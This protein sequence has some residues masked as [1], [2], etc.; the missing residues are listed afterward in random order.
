MHVL[1]MSELARISSSIF[2]AYGVPEKQADI[3]GKSLAK[4]NLLGHDSHG[5]IRIP[6]YITWLETGD[7]QPEAKIDI[8]KDIGSVVLIRGN[9]GFGQVIGRWAMEIAI[10]RA[11]ETGFVLMG[12]NRSGHLGRIGEYPEM[13]VEEGLLSLHFVNTHGGGKI[14]APYGGTE[15]RMSANPFAAGIP[16]PG[17]VPVIIDISTSAIAGGKVHVAHNRGENVPEGCLLDQNGRP[18]VD[19]T[20][21]VAGKGALLNFGG[22][23]GYAIGL[24]CDVLAGAFCDASCSHPETNRVANAMFSIVAKPGLLRDEDGFHQEVSRYI[25]YLKTSPLREGFDEILYPGEPEART[26]ERRTSEGISVDDTTWSEIVSV[27]RKCKV[28]I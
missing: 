19:P 25:D 17:R 27:A 6:Q 24:L 9:F 22:H 23:K 7:V 18:T 16:I 11:K 26:V 15:R 5:V 8:V 12:L 14:V 28:N 1:T 21:F 3:V 4:A 13:A 2:S 20:D 10:A